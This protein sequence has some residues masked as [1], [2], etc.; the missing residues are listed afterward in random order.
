MLTTLED[1]NTYFSTNVIAFFNTQWTEIDRKSMEDMRY[2]SKP[3]SV[4]VNYLKIGYKK[5]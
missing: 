2:F 4:F 1:S 3:V 5:E